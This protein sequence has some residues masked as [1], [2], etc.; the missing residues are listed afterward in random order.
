MS[1]KRKLEA[2]IEQHR[3]ASS[4]DGSSASRLLHTVPEAAATFNLSPSWLYAR[5]RTNEIPFRRFG[6]YIRF[7]DDDLAA[8]IAARGAS[9]KIGA[10]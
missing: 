2:K 9:L 6:K 8:I 5:T 4:V 10:E 7:T 3:T 1:K